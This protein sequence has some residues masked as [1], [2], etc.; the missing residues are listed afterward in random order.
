M[1][2]RRSINESTDTSRLIE[3]IVGELKRA[4]RVAR[5]ITASLYGIARMSAW[6]RAGEKLAAGNPKPLVRRVRNG[7]IL[8][9]LGR[10]LRK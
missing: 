5:S 3:G 7:F 2:E 4:F 1:C 8:G 6:A 10:I 9:Q